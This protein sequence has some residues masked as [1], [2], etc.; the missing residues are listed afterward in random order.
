VAGDDTGFELREKCEEDG[1]SDR[2]HGLPILLAVVALD[3]TYESLHDGRFRDCERQ[4]SIDVEGTNGRQV[5]L[6]CFGL[7]T[8]SETGDP[9]H[10]GWLGSGQDGAVGIVETMKFDMVNEGFLS[11]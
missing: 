3:T 7:N 6:N 9:G 1:E 11:G 2:L 10:D 5:A 8:T 4:V